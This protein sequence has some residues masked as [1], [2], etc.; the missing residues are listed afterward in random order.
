[1]QDLCYSPRVGGAGQRNMVFVDRG[2]HHAHRHNFKSLNELQFIEIGSRHLPSVQGR[3]GAE[4]KKRRHRNPRNL[5]ERVVNARLPLLR[6]QQHAAVQDER[7]EG[8]QFL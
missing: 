4:V 6:R 5:R 2:F 1:L 3:I 8:G 7:D